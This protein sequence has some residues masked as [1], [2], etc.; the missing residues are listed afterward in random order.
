MKL[1]AYSALA[2]VSS[3]LIGF[4]A[5]A[6]AQEVPA[7]VD[8]EFVEVV[9]FTIMWT[10][11]V[12]DVV[13]TRTAETPISDGDL[14]TPDPV[15]PVTTETVKPIR[16]LGPV[17]LYSD[18]LNQAGQHNAF[19]VNGDWNY[20]GTRNFYLDMVAVRAP[21]R[22][23]KEFATNP[24]RIY[25]TSRDRRTGAYFETPP[26]L[27]DV[28]DLVTTPLE[29]GMTLS[30][31]E[32]FQRTTE[33]FDA[34]GR[35]SNASGTISTS[36]KLDYSS[37]WFPNW[38]TSLLPRHMF[39]M[40][41]RGTAVYSI[42]TIKLP[43]KAS[44]P[45]YQPAFLAPAATTLRGVGYH[46][47]DYFENA[48]SRANYTHLGLAPLSITLGSAKY[49][50]RSVFPDFTI[51]PPA[52]PTDLSATLATDDQGALSA[53]L[54]WTDNANNEST[55]IVERRIGADGQWEEIAELPRNFDVYVD[56]DL[57]EGVDYFYR[58][59]ARNWVADSDN[60]EE[61]QAVAPEVPVD[62]APAG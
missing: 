50:S 56:G 42:R 43:A 15:A 49:V 5:P 61:V 22:T 18:L 7:P 60:S 54:L 58:V 1:S 52:A 29:Y 53:L 47:H 28:T 23:V 19:T 39:L 38:P 36:F 17:G 3:G 6:R 9:P 46:A 48:T 26:M 34:S 13:Q 59:H 2:A 40:N 24:Y 20:E 55:Y 21:A 45:G 27:P 41:A 14:T 8:P 12:S 44:E 37:N 25:L 62:P 51:L 35:V 10:R 57:E 32:Y 11:T 4:V 33:N 30:F 16:D 31:G